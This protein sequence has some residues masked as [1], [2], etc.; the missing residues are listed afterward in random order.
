MPKEP[1]PSGDSLIA[2]HYH[3]QQSSIDLSWAFRCYI[4]FDG[5]FI[6]EEDI[7][8]MNEKIY[9]GNLKSPSSDSLISL[10]PF[11]MYNLAIKQSSSIHILS[12]MNNRLGD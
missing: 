7:G 9:D 3:K 5:C 12:L 6:V 2:S 11:A 8:L 4:C 10:V 1:L